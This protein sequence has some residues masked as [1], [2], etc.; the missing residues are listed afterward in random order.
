MLSTLP[1]PDNFMG[2]MVLLQMLQIEK[3]ITMQLTEFPCHTVT[4][5][6]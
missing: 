4:I 2:L 5:L 3:L 6:I 1:Y